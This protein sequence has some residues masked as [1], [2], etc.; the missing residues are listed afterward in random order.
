M[1][2]PSSNLTQKGIAAVKAGN[3][4][5]ALQFL[6]A[7]LDENP[8][9]EAAW[10]WMSSV[11]T[12]VE[13]KRECLER[14]L[15][16]NPNSAPARR[17]LALLG[18]A[19]SIP[20]PFVS[21][22]LAEVPLPVAPAPPKTARPKPRP[23]AK[24]QRARRGQGVLL[25][26]LAVGVIGI[27]VIIAIV[28]S[29]SNAPPPA[30]PPP[31]P[32]S[33]RPPTWTPTPTPEATL[34]PTPRAAPTQLRPLVDEAVRV[35][36]LEPIKSITYV[37]TA[38]FD[39]DLYLRND[40][41][42]QAVVLANTFWN[43]MRALGLVDHKLEY[44]RQRVIDLT[45][46]SIA[47]FYSPTDKTLYA[48]TRS[49]RVDPN[50]YV[51]IVHEYVHALTDMH[52]DLSRV[53]YGEHTTDSD[54]AARALVEGDATL[55]E[56]LTP[57]AFYNPD[58]WEDYGRDARGA[59]PFY[60]ELGLSSAFLYINTFP[61]VE[62]WQ[63]VWTLRDGGG[64]EAV[65]QAYRNIPQSTEHILH[66]DRY[67]AGYNSPRLVELP[68]IEELA[69]E[70]YDL[71][72]EQDTLGEFVL[73]VV[74]DEFVREEE[75]TRQ[76]ADGWGGDAFRAW[77]DTFGN[78]AY[79]WLIGWDSADE[80]R[81]FMAPAAEMLSLRTDATPPFG[82]DTDRIYF[83]GEPGDAYLSRVDD[84]VLVIWATEDGLR[85]R[86]LEAITGF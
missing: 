59:A 35:R 65:N 11:V 20:S 17:G 42:A 81:E 52:F 71:V 55:A 4:N 72:V 73:W 75:R 63:F 80:A 33:T 69:I 39:V 40:V 18:P 12:T 61:Y 32:A 82:P 25:G 47:G 22:E 28:L 57:F 26:L 48:V 23:S 31:A 56:N 6:R 46:R 15:E 85:D 76:A 38:Q 83:D 60:R 21:P 34:T 2:G 50:E 43:E 49:S 79:A 5:L 44:D 45:S 7:A 68:P 41:D 37:T 9:D 74:L 53:L 27:V 84:Q 14:V 67:L 54:L 29:S 36:E 77:I 62:G 78:Q 24:P 51:I 13:E 58:G 66:P 1:S 3:R 86:I 8:N 70:G 30:A 64:W 10:L 19:H 16:I